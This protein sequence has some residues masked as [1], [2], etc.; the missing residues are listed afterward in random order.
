M[1][2]ALLIKFGGE[3]TNPYENIQIIPGS[4]MVLVTAYDS[5]GELLTDGMQCTAGGITNNTNAMG[6]AVFAINNTS[7]VTVTLHNNC[8]GLGLRYIDQSNNSIS[9]NVHNYNGTNYINKVLPLEM[10]LSRRTGTIRFNSGTA[11][12]YHFRVTNHIGNI[13]VLG[14]GGGGAALGMYYNAL[15]IT[16]SGN[17][18][19][20]TQSEAL[21]LVNLVTSTS[22]R[23]N[24]SSNISFPLYIA[25]SGYRLNDG[26]VGGGGGEYVSINRQFNVYRKNMKYEVGRGGNAG[27]Y[28]FSINSN[29]YIRSETNIY[30]YTPNSGWTSYLN[31]N[32]VINVYAVGGSGG[33]YSGSGGHNNINRYDRYGAVIVNGGDG[34]DET[35]NVTGTGLG[36]CGGGGYGH[37]YPGDTLNHWAGVDG[38]GNG[39]RCKSTSSFSA[40]VSASKGT[41]GGGGGDASMTFN[42]I[43]KNR[44]TC[45]AGSGGTGRVSFR[46]ID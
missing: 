25:T 31:I 12:N 26:G 7:N 18:S 29:G 1:G 8:V 19:N 38:G 27:G 35:N 15:N 23:Y 45:F 46:L 34:G 43:N 17:L 41:G 44:F 37:R 21:E 6:Q 13:L 33:F 30:S 40:G 32:G 20:M 2:E 36:V 39:L 9:L 14:G 16:S 3:V 11:E 24:S 28:N 22:Y 4:A 5:D 10:T 42:P